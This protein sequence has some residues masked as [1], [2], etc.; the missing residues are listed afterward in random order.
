MNF[1]S[2]FYIP[3]YHLAPFV[4]PSVKAPPQGSTTK[5]LFNLLPSLNFNYLP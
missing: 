4:I 5:V 3:G 2:N 1:C